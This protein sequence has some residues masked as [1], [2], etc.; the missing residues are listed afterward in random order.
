M[1]LKKWIKVTA[2]LALAFALVGCENAA[3]VAR[4]PAVVDQMVQ[5]AISVCQ[6][7]DSAQAY[8]HRLNDALSQARTA[9]L[10][11]LQA[12]NVTVCLDHRLNA[13][14]TGFWDTPAEGVLYNNQ[15]GGKIATLWDNGRA[16]EDAGLFH[17][18][19]S[20]KSGY[21]IRAFAGALRDGKVQ[22]TDQRWYAFDTTTSDGNGNVYVSSSARPEAKF[23]KDTVAK[24][25]ALKAAPV[26][27]APATP[28]VPGA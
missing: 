1:A 8:G 19:A 5:N 12:N 23:D 20:G 6:V 24:N 10:D 17:R 21:I 3:D 18:S 26:K 25:P 15:Q 16:P 7:P 14:N 9:D 11:T 13:Q 22:P 27:A 4:K 28:T 2:P